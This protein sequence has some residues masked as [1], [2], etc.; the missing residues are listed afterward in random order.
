MDDEG[1]ELMLIDRSELFTIKT[2]NT[3]IISDACG[4]RSLTVC[5]S[6]T[7][8]DETDPVC[9]IM[10]GAVNDKLS[11]RF[12]G[13]CRPD[14]VGQHFTLMFESVFSE[15]PSVIVVKEF[16][17]DWFINRQTDGFIPGVPT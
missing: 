7:N 16:L 11:A 17:G 6:L 13:A 1:E 8:R 2:E 10:I 3:F 14:D 9:I 15:T 12:E 5:A 4:D